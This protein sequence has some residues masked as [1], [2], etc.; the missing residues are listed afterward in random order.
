MSCSTGH[1]CSSDPTLLWLWQWPAAA[2]PIQPLAWELPYAMGV[3]LK[4]TESKKQNETKQF[5]IPAKNTFSD[6]RIQS[7]LFNSL[8]Y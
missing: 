6:L 8:Q 1:R 5:Q 4:K 2:A 3:V 7:Q